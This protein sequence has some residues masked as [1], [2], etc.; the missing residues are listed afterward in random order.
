MSY[1]TKT[2]RINS[3]CFTMFKT[4]MAIVI[5]KNNNKAII[6]TMINNFII[7]V[8][9]L[10][11]DPYK[12]NV[13]LIITNLRTITPMGIDNFINKNFESKKTEI[14]N[15]F[16][17]LLARLKLKSPSSFINQIRVNV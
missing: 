14:L 7:K 13:D 1:Q 2:Y 10:R 15:Q 4:S 5:L 12:F 17:S 11:Q 16:T 3:K 8:N 9:K 6:S